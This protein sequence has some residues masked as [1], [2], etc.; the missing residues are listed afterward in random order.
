M[1]SRI[2]NIPI[3]ATILSSVATKVCMIANY[4]L[5]QIAENSKK[6]NSSTLMQYNAKLFN[7]ILFKVKNIAMKVRIS[8]ITLIV[9]AL[10]IV[11]K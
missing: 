6:Y 9:V 7:K 2:N 1:H 4:S 3:N 10:K 11:L 5:M 8:V